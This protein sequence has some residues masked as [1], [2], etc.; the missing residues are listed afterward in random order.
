MIIAI[1]GLIGSGKTSLASYLE[2]EY[3][4]KII[5]CDQIVSDLYDHDEKMQQ[6]VLEL[7]G[8]KV[9][10]RQKIGEIVFKDAGKLKNLEAIIHPLIESECKKQLEIDRDIVFDCQII[11]KLDIEYD[12]AIITTCNYETLKKRVMTRD[13]RSS[14][15][16]NAILN[17]QSNTYLLE[18]RS[19]VIDT[20]FDYQED[21]EKIIR[22]FNASENWQ[23]S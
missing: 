14:D 13:N 20:T 10:D 12:F 2:E 15:S 19:Y 22:S 18:K 11:E 23:N 5:T 4:F 6:A 17:N 16:F 9:I 3:D 1:R 8:L 7:L 21:I